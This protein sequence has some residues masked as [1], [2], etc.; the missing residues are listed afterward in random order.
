MT[1]GQ[2]LLLAIL[3]LAALNIAFVLWR[4]WVTRRRPVVWR[5]DDAD[6]EPY[7]DPYV[8]GLAERR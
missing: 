6:D 1:F 3:V 2:G 5:Q 8:D 7:R 4:H